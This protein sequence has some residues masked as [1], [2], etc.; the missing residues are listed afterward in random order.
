[1]KKEPN[2]RNAVARRIRFL[3]TICTFC[4]SILE[5]RGTVLERSV[6]GSHIH[7][8]RILENF[9]GFTFWADMGQ[10]DLGGNDMK[11]WHHSGRQ[12]MPPVLHLYWQDQFELCTLQ[13]FDPKERWQK[14][15]LAV[16]K[17]RKTVAARTDA[18]ARTAAK[19]REAEGLEQLRQQRL[20]DDAKRL[21][22]L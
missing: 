22:V 18:A 19:K 16:I 7:E 21:K 13:V 11:I 8:R 17:N 12:S 9:G 10:S 4:Q 15:L 14:N 1:M 5:E 6:G 3:Q 2:L 20:E